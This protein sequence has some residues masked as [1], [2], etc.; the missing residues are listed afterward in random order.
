MYVL[1]VVV[2]YAH[3][4][5]TNF[6]PLSF[7]FCVAQPD[8]SFADDFLFPMSSRFSSYTSSPESDGE[9]CESAAGNATV[10]ETRTLGRKPTQSGSPPSAGQ[11]LSLQQPILTGNGGPDRSGSG[12]ARSNS[13]PSLAGGVMQ[14]PQQQQNPS[15][16]QP[17]QSDFSTPA[18]HNKVVFNLRI[19]SPRYFVHNS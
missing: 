19:S 4:C 14:S 5:T 16:P 10:L 1:H 18:S 12:L 8:E 15:A 6:C 7:L 2:P 17:N 11:P 9:F 3:R 13:D